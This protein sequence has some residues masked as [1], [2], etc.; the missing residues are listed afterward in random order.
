LVIV[1]AALSLSV[2]LCEANTFVRL[3]TNL[4]NFTV[5]LSEDSMPV[6]VANFLGYV[7]SGRYARSFFHRSTTYNPSTIQIVQGGGFF[8][9]NNNSIEPV[10]A[11]LPIALEPGPSNVRGT[12]AMAR[13]NY[14][15]SATSQWFFNVTDNPAL[16]FNYAVFGRIVG[17]EGLSILDAI[18]AVP[19][20][21]ASVQL[22]GVFAEL[23]LIEP[24]LVA[25]S[26]VSV[27]SVDE[28]SLG[29]SSQSMDSEGFRINWST[30][31]PGLPVSVQR[32]T[33]LGGAAEWVS[34]S[35]NNTTG[36][37]TDVERPTSRGFYR[38]VFP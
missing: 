27:E 4:G 12:I 25:S 31:P 38:I 7:R 24:N 9:S 13:T 35:S 17:P 23:P 3:S 37:F 5:E 18:G 32:C 14:P 2:E 1:F 34:I 22:G 28:I 29:I 16:D 15:N 30:S 11:D 26:L 21:D 6:T 19:V 10:V 8:L 33:D 36:T 20:Y